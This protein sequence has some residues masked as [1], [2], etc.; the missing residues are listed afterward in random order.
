[1]LPLCSGI[2]ELCREF[3]GVKCLLDFT[4]FKILRINVDTLIRRILS[5]HLVANDVDLAHGGHHTR[6]HDTGKRL[7][8][9]PHRLSVCWLLIGRVE[10]SVTWMHKRGMLCS[11]C[12]CILW[13]SQG[14][15]RTP[16]CIGSDGPQLRVAIT[17]ST[18]V[19]PPYSWSLRALDVDGGDKR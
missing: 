3:R 7:G 2:F 18:G 6:T 19:S 13:A 10:I 9:R 1:M 16:R 12:G 11:Q 15:V 17:P 14:E 8:Q 5:W 4:F